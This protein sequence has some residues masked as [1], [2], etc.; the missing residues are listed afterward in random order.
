MAHISNRNHEHGALADMLRGA[1][2]F[3][4]VSRAR[5]W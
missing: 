3:V 1:D 2:A 4:G 5:I